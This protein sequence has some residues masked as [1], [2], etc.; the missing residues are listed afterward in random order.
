M[1][2]NNDVSMPNHSKRRTGLIGA[3]VACL[4]IV[5]L[6]LLF[7]ALPLESPVQ[8]DPYHEQF[9]NE[10]TWK[11]GEGVNAQGFVV[12]GVYEL[13]ID[14]DL[15][16]DVFWAT[17]G[18]NFADGRYEVEASPLE[19]AIDNGYGMLFRVDEGKE[20]FYVFKVSSDGYVFVGR[21]AD[22]CL[23]Q[24]AL[25]NQDWFDSPSIQTG[26]GVTN[27][28]KVDVTGSEMVFFVN[29]VEVGRATDDTLKKG[30]IGLLAETFTPGGLIVAFDNFR[31][32]PIEDAAD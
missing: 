27:H 9:D 28:L 17:A 3:G 29:G 10:G 13:S 23:E 6:I 12:D 7:V 11:V 8:T 26:F 5:G 24:E 31:I 4:I 30:D 22:S 18:E 16:G 20:G 1:S 14:P 25:V 19:G 32:M 15:G 2:A 21:C